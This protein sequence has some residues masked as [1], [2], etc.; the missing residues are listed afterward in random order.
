MTFVEALILV[1]P[2]ALC[3]IENDSSARKSSVDLTR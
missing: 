2:C 1:A 3:K